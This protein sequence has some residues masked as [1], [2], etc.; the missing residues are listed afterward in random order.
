MLAHRKDVVEVVS[1]LAYMLK[2]LDPDGLEIC[3]TQSTNKV[4]SGRSTKLSKA[5][6][7]VPFYGISNMRMRLGSIF[8]EHQNDLGTP[9]N[10]PGPW[11]KRAAPPKAKNGVSFYIFTDGK[12]QPNNDVGSTIKAI[13]DYMKE[14]KLPKEHVGIQ[15]IR[16]GEDPDG[17][18]HLNHLDHGLGLKDID[19]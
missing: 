13:V 14:H 9:T 15:F 6:N 7:Q 12:Y 1:L 11:Y 8:H 2:G 19:M 3:F 17:I 18:D 5:V 4:Q 16:F 10:P